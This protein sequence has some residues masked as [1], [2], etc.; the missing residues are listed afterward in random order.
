[1]RRKNK[2]QNIAFTFALL[3]IF[4]SGI[5]FRVSIAEDVLPVAAYIA[6]ELAAGAQPYDPQ[7]PENL[8]AE[9]LYAKSAI[10]IEAT[11][12][13]VIFEKN[14]DQ[15]MYPASTTKILTVFL[16]IVKESL[17]LRLQRVP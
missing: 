11:S 1:M 2:A 3:I 8:L 4:L 5:P 13:K 12:G 17:I 6:P 7:K 16:G 9:Q 15:V 10:L 14:A